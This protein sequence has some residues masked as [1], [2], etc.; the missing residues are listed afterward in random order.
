MLS[1]LKK[2]FGSKSIKATQPEAAPYKVEAPVVETPAAVVIPAAGLMLNVKDA[3]AIEVAPAEQKPVAKKVA[4][5]KAPRKPR[6]PK[7]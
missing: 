5:P 6:T 3:G 1:F 4:K 7:V 2:I